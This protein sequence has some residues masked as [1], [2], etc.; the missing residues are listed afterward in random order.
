MITF[1]LDSSAGRDGVCGF[2]SAG[3][4]ATTWNGRSI[5]GS[6]NAAMC[7]RNRAIRTGA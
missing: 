5:P 1:N 7:L 4:G 3:Q 6:C 2:A